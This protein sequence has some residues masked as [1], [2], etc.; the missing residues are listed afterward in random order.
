MSLRTQVPLSTSVALA[1]KNGN[2]LTSVPSS[3]S[4]FTTQKQK[5]M[6]IITITDQT[7]KIDQNTIK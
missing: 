2:I 7:K 3:A 6:N 1:L 4:S 5:L